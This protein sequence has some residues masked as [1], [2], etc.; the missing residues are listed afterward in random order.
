M[1]YVRCLNS[2]DANRFQQALTPRGILVYE[3]TTLVSEMSCCWPSCD[4]GYF[5]SKMS[6]H[7]PIGIR[8]RNNKL[9]G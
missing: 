2:E 8:R 7:I 5:V 1:T 6:M 4:I 9:S 3:T